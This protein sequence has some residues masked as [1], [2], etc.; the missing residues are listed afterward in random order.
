MPHGCTTYPWNEPAGSLITL[1][2]EQAELWG[3]PGWALVYDQQTAYAALVALE[4]ALTRALSDP[5]PWTPPPWAGPGFPTGGVE[6]L[7]PIVTNGLPPDEQNTPPTGPPIH[8]MGNGW[9][10]TPANDPNWPAIQRARDLL[11]K[12]RDALDS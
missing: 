2:D 1:L 8:A 7:A 4:A 9:L 3:R 6:V 12:I 5:S 10:L 11:E